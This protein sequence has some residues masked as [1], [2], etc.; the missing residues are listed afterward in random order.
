M[1]YPGRCTYSFLLKLACCL[2]WEKKKVSSKK[3]KEKNLL[4]LNN[5]S[6]S[7]DFVTIICNPVIMSVSMSN[8]KNNTPPRSHGNGQ[9]SLF[10]N[11]SLIN[12]NS[13]KYLTG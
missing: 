10:L 12:I 4:L 6:R 5:G 1:I 3:K 13:I 11:V 2:D 8:L 9:Y 7:D